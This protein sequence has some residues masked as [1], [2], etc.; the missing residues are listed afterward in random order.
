MFL[1][2]LQFAEKF[3][4]TRPSAGLTSTMNAE[5]AEDDVIYAE[6]GKF[7]LLPMQS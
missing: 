4:S 3:K 6:I 1:L 2:L 5:E 7:V